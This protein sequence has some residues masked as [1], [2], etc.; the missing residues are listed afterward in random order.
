MPLDETALRRR[1]EIARRLKAARW[2]AGSVASNERG[3][4]G[5]RVTQLSPEDLA[6]RGRLSENGITATLIGAIERMERHTPPME[7]EA[8]A[9]ALGVPRSWFEL[10]APTGENGEL[11]DSALSRAAAQLAPQLLAAAR[12]LRQ[13]RAPG[14]RDVDAPG[15]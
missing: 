13:E 3:E 14:L 11:S 2:L 9:D 8:I 12:A 4:T 6:R 15:P 10:E 5:Y 7:L 1:A